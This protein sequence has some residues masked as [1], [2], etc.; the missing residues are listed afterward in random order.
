M[1][2][3][4]LQDHGVNQQYVG[5]LA[6]GKKVLIFLEVTDKNKIIKNP[7]QLETEGRKKKKKKGELKSAK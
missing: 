1:H 6:C 5:M 4:A 7:K 2:N 3:L